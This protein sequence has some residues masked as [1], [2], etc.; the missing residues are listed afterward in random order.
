[1]EREIL[2]SDEDIE[3]ILKIAVQQTGRHDPT[4]RDRLHAA[5]N[6]LGISPEELQA[7]ERKFTRESKIKS[8]LAEYDRYR[9]RDFR[10][11]FVIYCI[12]NAFL[13]VLN[14]FTRDPGETGFW[15]IFPMLGW[16][17]GIAMHGFGTYATQATTESEE[18][19][20][21]YRSK[22][23]AEAEAIDLHAE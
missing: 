5:A 1:M 4:L 6:E 19:Q 8:A 2:Q 21:W 9:K 16:G 23:Q 20:K 10:N 22:K 18:F 13:V 17:I 12:V 11:H 15:A 14:L 7:A 3:A